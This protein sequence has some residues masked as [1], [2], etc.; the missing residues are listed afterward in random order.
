V[1]RLLAF[2]LKRC[3]LPA[4]NDLVDAYNL[5]S[6]RSFCSL[7]AH[8]LNRIILPVSLRILNGTESFT[9]LGSNQPVPSM[10]GEF[11]YVDA[12]NRLLCRLDILQADFSKVTESTKNAL[13]IVEGTDTHSQ[14]IIRQACEDVIQLVTHYCGGAG[15]IVCFPE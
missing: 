15:E 3:D 10:A 11:G 1:E 7:G 8:D 6:I 9:P 5:I 2:S 4:I 13:M 14:Q 12:S